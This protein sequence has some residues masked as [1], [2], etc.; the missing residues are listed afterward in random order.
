MALKAQ[1]LGDGWAQGCP[2][3]GH[4]AHF[5]WMGTWSG[6]RLLKITSRMRRRE[7]VVMRMRPKKR[8]SSVFSEDITYLHACICVRACEIA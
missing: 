5:S 8:G 6:S 7:A 3:T 1:G 4:G 2:G